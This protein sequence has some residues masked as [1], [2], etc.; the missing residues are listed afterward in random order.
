[1]SVQTWYL[2]LMSGEA[3]PFAMKPG[4]RAWVTRVELLGAAAGQSMCVA[5]LDRSGEVQIRV[6]LSAEWPVQ[7]V[8]GSMVMQDDDGFCL[9]RD[10]DDCAGAVVRF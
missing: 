7:M 10:D 4:H 1:M 3:K 9:E 6:M 5:L 2:D 8:V